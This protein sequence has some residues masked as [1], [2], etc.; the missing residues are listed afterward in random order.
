MEYGFGEPGDEDPVF[1]ASARP[2]RQRGILM[3]IESTTR[4]LVIDDDASNTQPL[5]HFL[6]SRD[7]TVETCCGLGH[8][9]DV[10]ARWRPH[11]M[12][13]VPREEADLH[14][15]MEELRRMSPRVPVVMLTLAAGP[16]LILDMEAFAPTV[17]VCPSRD[18]AYI[19][20]AVADASAMG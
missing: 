3:E 18:L 5:V 10:L 11:V 14:S 15:E 12:V 19:E 8:A 20:S 4:V 9:R 1:G 13:L 7:Y 2:S 6:S 17:P 16:E